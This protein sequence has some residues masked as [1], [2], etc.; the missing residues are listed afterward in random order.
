MEDNKFRLSILS[1]FDNTLKLTWLASLLIIT[2]FAIIVKKI[3]E[4]NLNIN[5]NLL[6]IISLSLF[7]ILVFIYYL[8]IYRISRY[9]ITNDMVVTYK[10]IFV[11]DRKEILIKNIANI[12]V[13]Q[14]IFERILPFLVDNDFKYTNNAEESFIKF[15]IRDIVKHSILSIPISSI[16]VII[17]FIM[18][19][20]TMFQN[21]SLLK[22]ISYN[23]LGL[24][25]TLVGFIFPVIYSVAKNLIKYLNYY[26]KRKNKNIY[27]SFGIFTKKLYIIPVSKINGLIADVS[28]LCAI[29]GCY[30]L[31]V[32][33]SGI[34]DSKNKLSMLFPI[35]KKKKCINILK[36]ILP[37]YEIPLKNKNQASKSLVVFGT[38]IIILML[39]LV[40]PCIYINI[41]I[42]L[43][44]SLSLLILTFIIY[45]IKR[46]VI[47]DKYI[48]VINGIFLKRLQI[49]RYEKIENV[50]I[51]DGIIS[52][53]MGICK[54]YI[55]IL[56]N[57][58]NGK[59]SS[60]Y[61]KRIDAK[62]IVAKMSS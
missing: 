55:S 34:G 27:V 1:I 10:N 28:L 12:C 49:I 54:V 29:F 19:L 53:Q 2:N 23:F 61:I 32:I 40:I 41:K 26:V 50:N 9:E 43:L 18:L 22:E 5:I 20:F 60:G 14:N 58:K 48:C 57:L 44:I 39:M 13:S 33:T 8:V 30:K 31:N 36:L 38:K 56:G 59:I 7:I 37:E 35:M 4:F 42:A 51:R 46:I 45:L 24:I 52:K 17:N 47:L 6:L 21:G 11:K 15:K 16:I 62:N 25:I 3:N